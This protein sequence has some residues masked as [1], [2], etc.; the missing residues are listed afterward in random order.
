MDDN[1]P[2]RPAAPIGWL[3]ALAKSE[4]QLAAGEIVDGAEVMHEL[5]ECIA[6]LEARQADKPHRTATPHR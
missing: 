6:E 3:E 5:D 1:T 2:R 4:A